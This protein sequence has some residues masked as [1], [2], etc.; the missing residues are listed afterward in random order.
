MSRTLSELQELIFDTLND[1]VTLRT[2]LGGTGRVKYAGV[3]N[4]AEYPVV[5]YQVIA[6]MDNAYNA[7]SPQASIISSRVVIQ[8]FVNN[9]SP[10]TA[11]AIDDRI[12]ALFN[13]QALSNTDVKVFSCYRV[14]RDEVYD[15]NVKV[16]V[17]TS[18]YNIV[19]TNA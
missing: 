10:L 8:T 19:N 11:A 2:L 15:Y 9:T 12:Y 18:S 17:I 3:Q 7:D 4:K 6:E 14:K 16:W 13:G 5:T 1:D